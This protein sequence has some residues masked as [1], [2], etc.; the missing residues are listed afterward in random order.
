[1]DDWSPVLE[2]AVPVPSSPST[3]SFSE[4]RQELLQIPGPRRGQFL[5]SEAEV[6]G[7]ELWILR[8]RDSAYARRKVEDGL[9]YKTLLSNLQGEVSSSLVSDAGRETLA[10]LLH[11]RILEIYEPEEGGKSVASNKTRLKSRLRAQV[12]CLQYC[13]LLIRRGNQASLWEWCPPAVPLLLE[14]EAIPFQTQPLADYQQVLNA[15][16]LLV[17]GMQQDAPSGEIQTY[18]EGVILLAALLFGGLGEMAA[19]KR[20]FLMLRRRQAL[21]YFE[22]AG[23]A[24]WDLQIP[25]SRGGVR[26]RRWFP[27]P[28]SEILILRYLHDYPLPAKDDSDMHHQNPEISV[29]EIRQRMTLS[30]R[31]WPR[32]GRRHIKLSTLFRGMTQAVRLELPQFL[33]AYAMGELD[34]HALASSSWWRIHGCLEAPQVEAAGVQ[35][36]SANTA[37]ATVET[38][39][40]VA[41]GVVTVAWLR[42]LRQALRAK[43][44]AAALKGIKQSRTQTTVSDPLGQ[45]MFAWA[46]HLLKE[47]SSFRHHLAM[48][49]IRRYVSR[50]AALMLQVL[51][52]TLLVESF[53]DPSWRQLYEA[54]LEQVDTGHQRVHLIRAIREWHQ[55]LVEHQGLAPLPLQDLGGFQ[56]DVIP[57]A[58]VISESEFN[59]L[60]N[61][62]QD[63]RHVL[64]HYQLPDLLTLVVI[65]GYRCGLR[66]MEVLR[67]RITDCHLEGQAR[68]LI[69]PFS[70]RRLKTR[71][72]TRALPLDVLLENAELD[73]LKKW[74]AYRGESGA[75]SPEEYLFVLPE[76]GHNPIAQETAMSRIHAD[77][78]TVTGDQNLHFHHLRHSFANQVLWKLMLADIDPQYLPLKY[79]EEQASAQTFRQRLLG[80]DHATRKQLYA[81]AALLG[82]SGPEISLNHYLHNLD[83]ILALHLR[84]AIS[85]AQPVREWLNVLR[86]LLHEKTIYRAYAQD[87]LEGLLSRLRI[88][89]PDSVQVPVSLQDHLIPQH[90]AFATGQTQSARK[91]KLRIEDVWYL[92]LQGFTQSAAIADPQRAGDAA[93]WL[94][95]AADA[96]FSTKQLAGMARKAQAIFALKSRMGFRHNS[97][98]IPQFGRDRLEIAL[99]SRPFTQWDQTHL[100]NMLPG[101]WRR[102]DQ[103]STMLRTTL[104][105]YLDRAW[106][107]EPGYLLIRSP[108]DVQEVALAQAYKQLL[109]DLGISPRNIRYLSFDH[110]KQRSRWREHWRKVLHLNKR[111]LIQV[112]RAYEKCESS[113]AS[114]LQ[115]HPVFERAGRQSEGMSPAFS[116]LMVMGA[117]VL[118]GS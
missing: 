56:M 16:K 7:Y 47:G 45:R 95:I 100:K 86:G 88:K 39:P 58:Q 75:V 53:G 12:K 70:E 110:G 31:N 84:A 107:S 83:L 64:Q 40:E 113:G 13:S 8:E 48:T 112:K 109:L 51:E 2:V 80:V 106:R 28:F 111:D 108:E 55:F 33:G 105:A 103:D 116:Y 98:K 66:R 62:L 42:A 5:F 74:V 22:S 9:P 117:V 29:Q 30:L 79:R 14:R 61:A 73:L 41:E 67:L 87:G 101:F 37:D 91:S 1:M 59:R 94:E 17:Q 3:S 46:E 32:I 72:A 11:D 90:S 82:H 89:I 97:L 114:W 69:R 78:R 71:N 102:A 10:T 54:L 85:R 96:D 63:R 81:V 50:L 99:P 65:L 68:L 36:L 52:N 24:F 15:R 60:K 93:F 104:D 26:L 4:I 38:A 20:M 57:D 25:M 115:I 77:M 18:R 49:T 21:I 44:R 27:D 92:L 6:R 34:A 76:I 118:A 19:L 43:N 35:E 23:L